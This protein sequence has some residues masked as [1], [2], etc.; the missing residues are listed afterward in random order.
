MPEK[1]AKHPGRG[2]ES[3]DQSLEERKTSKESGGSEGKPCRPGKEASRQ[4]ARKTRGPTAAQLSQ[5][6]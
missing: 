5:V 1:W 6:C 4:P 2:K 3:R